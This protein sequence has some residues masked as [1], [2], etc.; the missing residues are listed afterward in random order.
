MV[1]S[2]LAKGNRLRV[3]KFFA[4]GWSSQRSYPAIRDQVIAALSEATHTGWEGL[5][6]GQRAYLDRFWERA[7][8]E[9][10][11]DTEL[12]QAVRFGLFHT[13]QAGARAEQRAIPAKGL[14]GPGYDGHTFWDT[15]RFVLPV[16]TYT[17]PDAARDA[18]RW[19]HVTL[20]LARERA[21]Q[22]G[23]E[24]AAFPW[25]TIR[26]QECSGYWPAGTA[27]FHI[28]A[29]IADAVQRYYDTTSDDTFDREV[30]LEL[31]VE[32]ARL[33]RSLGHHD[34]QGRFRIDGVTGPDEYSAVADNNVYTNLM[35]QRNL[36]A[37]ADAVAR[38][39]R[40]AAE[41]DADFEE[42]AAWRDAARDMV[43]PWDDALGVHPQ[44]E[45][46]TNHEVWDFENTRP[47]Q[48]PLLLHFAYFDLYRK[49]VAKQAD[50]VLALHARG[51][52]FTHEEKVRDFEYYERLT[53][54]DS[55]LSACTQAVLAAETGHL[56]LAYDYFAEAAFMDL[57]DLEHNTRDG[58]HIASLAGAWLAAVAGFGGM[59]DYDGKLTFSP[60]LP[61]RLTRLRF[62]L[63]FRG[64]CLRVDVTKKNATYALLEGEPLRIAHHGRALDLTTTDALTEEIPSLPERPRPSQP[65]GREPTRRAPNGS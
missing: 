5:L 61:A 40:R 51:D 19:R 63:V 52:A 8:V 38:H 32:T 7:D 16:L 64:R 17:E 45:G 55:S 28:G 50:L 21:R 9:L 44:S 35:A 27:A 12:Q 26:G 48:Y 46:F 13:L 10:E 18:L 49:Q 24:G 25:R 37:A 30:G 14:T 42:A 22:L 43:V 33:W 4:Y 56:E 1:A 15:E 59:R 54:R 31:L 20:E 23:L 6:A 65:H 47:D 36:R 39:P 41:L 2:D 53:V 62:R 58:V 3:V 11:G 34:P 29:D 60:R 57:R